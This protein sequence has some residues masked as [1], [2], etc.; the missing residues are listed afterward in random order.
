[1]EGNALQQAHHQL[2]ALWGHAQQRRHRH[3]T[4]GDKSRFS[5]GLGGWKVMRSN[6]R[7]TRLPLYGLRAH[8]VAAQAYKAGKLPL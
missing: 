8:V 2:A 3:T 7:H 4:K 5:L 6:T 1:M